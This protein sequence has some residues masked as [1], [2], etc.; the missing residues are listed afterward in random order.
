MRNVQVAKFG[1][2]VLVLTMAAVPARAQTF[3]D[4]LKFKGTNGASP[5]FES[6][7][8]GIDGNLYGTT[9]FGD[10]D[11]NYGTVFRITPK[12]LRKLYTFCSLPSC[13]DGSAPV[14]GL[15]LATDRNFYGTTSAGG[16]PT[17]NA[18]QGCGTI[19]KITSTGKL[20]TLHNFEYSDGFS[21]LAALVQGIDGNFYGTTYFGGD[22]THCDPPFG[23]GTVFKI[24]PD[25]TFTTL[26]IF[27]GSDGSFPEA[28]LIQ[29]SD[30]NFYGLTSNGGSGNCA[31]YPGGCGTIF[32]LTPGG[33]LTLL[34]EFNYSDGYFPYAA[35]VEASDGSLY[36]TTLQG[37]SYYGTVFNITKAG[38]LTTLHLFD[39][40]DG[41]FPHGSLVQGTDG[42]LYGSTATG[43]NLS[44]NRVGCG[45]AF[46]IKPDGTFTML[47]AFSGLD[48]AVPYG[49]LMQ[50]TNGKFFGTTYDGGN[51]DCD[52]HNGCGVVYSLDMGL[53]P[54]VTFVRDSG[55]I[56]SPISLLG[57]GF[58]GTSGVSLNGIPASFTVVSDTFVRA[59]VPEGA[60]TGFVAVTTPSR[61][62]TSNVQF[63][64]IR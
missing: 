45:T 7:V 9:V 17:C 60:A 27:D 4:V 19:F 28:G 41:G 20:T 42:N 55:K 51:L 5:E 32:K 54:F 34:Y 30:G 15:L 48:G 6:L 12:G 57:Q 64:V 53:G 3:T 43:G 13:A 52:S 26:H 39:S 21:P 8:Q 2:A 35:L 58:T 14:A 11:D 63:H 23:C 46:A 47:Y 59:A 36:G 29:A 10:S 61:T 49:G 37:P 25:G 18:P 50:A 1:L 22:I 16:D 44:C 24:T 62:L 38:V 40:N 33:S 31:G 56:G